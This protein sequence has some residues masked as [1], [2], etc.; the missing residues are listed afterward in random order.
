MGGMPWSP[1][2]KRT[3]SPLSIRR[4]CNG[5]ATGIRRE[6]LANRL[7]SAR[8]F[9]ERRLATGANPNGVAISPDG[10]FRLCGESLER[11]PD[12]SGHCARAGSRN[13]RSGRPEGSFAI[14]AR[15][16]DCFTPRE[17]C[18]QGQ[19]ACITCHPDNHIDGVAWNLETPQ[20]GRDR[21]ANRTLRGVAET[22]PYKWNGHNPDLETQC[23]PRIAKF[24]FHSEGF[25]KEQLADLVAFI[26]SIPLVAQSP[27]C[28]GWTIDVQRRNTA[29]KFFQEKLRHLPYTGNALH[30]KNQF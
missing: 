7:D 26:K 14:A 25:N 5:G 1:P 2:R 6:Q 13:D 19:F 22:A 20:L 10:Q 24:L 17:F 27:S 28:R 30:R 8:T 9:V 18:F 23:G 12:G 11:Q 4:S 21:V 16:T 29:R 15:R 3:S